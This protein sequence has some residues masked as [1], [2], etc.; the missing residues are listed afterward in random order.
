MIEGRLVRGLGQA[1]HFTRIE[2][3]RRQFVELAAIDPF[4]GTVNLTLDDDDHRQRWRSWCEHAVAGVVRE[5][6]SSCEAKCYPARVE[7]RIPAAIVVPQVDDY[8]LDKVELVAALPLC[9]HLA[10]E[11]GMR[12]RVELCRPLVAKAVLFDLDGTLVD[13]IGAY[14]ELARVAASAHGFEVTEQHVRESLCSGGNFWKG[15]VPDARPDG[16]EVRRAL[17]AHAAREWP[18][19]LREQGRVLD[20]LVDTLDALKRK[21]IALAI[22]SGARPEVLELF[23]DDD[24]LARFDVVI[25]GADVTRRKPDPEGIV[26]ALDALGVAPGDAVYVGDT[27]LDIRASRAAGV[28]AV[29]VLTGAGDS[30]LLSAHEPDRLIASHAKLDGI[31]APVNRAARGCPSPADQA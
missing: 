21:G 4:P 27:P 3:V 26:N 13:T 31:I 7:G 29:A 1:A 30:A 14:F 11:E 15:I 19:V 17:S 23:R 25:L 16:A 2:G 12:V 18:R 9:R 5:D 10:L 20:G 8:P 28:R 24:L 22:V 6:L